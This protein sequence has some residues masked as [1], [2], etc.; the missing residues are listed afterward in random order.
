MSKGRG[1]DEGLRKEGRARKPERHAPMFSE[2]DDLTLLEDNLSEFFSEV[3][4]Y[5]K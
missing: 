5:L 3:M 1:G 2:T 4:D